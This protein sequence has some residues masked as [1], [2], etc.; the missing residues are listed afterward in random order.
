MSF[1]PVS[2]AAPQKEDLERVTTA[3]P[4]PRGLVMLDDELIVLARGRVRGAGGVSAEVNDRAGTLFAVDPNVTEPVTGELGEAVRTNGR[5]LAEPTEPPFKL[6]DRASTPPESDRETDRPYCVLRYHEASRNL[7]LCAFSGI[8]KPRRPGQSSFSKNLTDALFRYDLRTNRWHEVERH[9]IEAGGSYPHH[10]PQYNDPPHGWLNGPNNCLVLGDLLYAVAK[11]NS[12]LVRYDLSGLV[13]DP[14]AGPP[15]SEYVLGDRISLEG[16]S[17]LPLYGHSALAF[18]DGWLYLGTRTNSV[19]VRFRLDD[20]YNPV[21]PMVGELVARFDPYNPATMKSAD[22]TDMDIDAEGR[23][24]VVSAKP[25][26]LYR[27][28][29]DPNDVFDARDGGEAPW[30]DLAG[31]TENPAMKS[32]NVLVDGERVFVTSGDGYAYQEGAAGTVYR[33]TIDD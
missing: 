10:D 1:A 16:G 19:I 9:N 18:H 29:P 7:F 17:V 30:A 3:V 33:L 13:E 2:H 12:R 32:E 24:Y 11:D 8:D 14:E 28:T 5:I 22:I 25:S 21:H 23:V 26:R 4:F 6:W 27:F 20:N 31:L 15:A